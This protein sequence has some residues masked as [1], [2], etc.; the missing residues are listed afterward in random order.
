MQLRWTPTRDGFHVTASVGSLE[1]ALS[2]TMHVFT[3]RHWPST[4]P[5]IRCATGY[6]LPSSIASKVS[7]IGGL[8]QFPHPRNRQRTAPTTSFAERLGSVPNSCAPQCEGFVTPGFLA[9]Q[10]RVPAA[11]SAAPQANNSM[12]VAEFQQEYF[13]PKD[14]ASFG[15][16][17]SRN[18]SVNR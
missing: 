2:T 7:V 18:V 13:K 3:H 16:A 15:A 4:R 9:D 6:A 11:A 17:C 10:Y 8:L 5:I 12:A 1:A 14:L